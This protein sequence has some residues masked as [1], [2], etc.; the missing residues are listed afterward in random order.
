M[1]LI[2]LSVNVYQKT[3]HHFFFSLLLFPHKYPNSCV[4]QTSLERLWKK[5][6]LITNRWPWLLI[7][8]GTRP[9]SQPPGHVLFT[10][11]FAPSLSFLFCFLSVCPPDI[12]IL[13]RENAGTRPKTAE[14]LHH[15]RGK[16]NTRQQKRHRETEHPASWRRPLFV[17]RSQASKYFL[18]V[19]FLLPFLQLSKQ[20]EMENVAFSLFS[21]PFGW[22]DK[23]NEKK[24]PC[25]I[26]KLR[27]AKKESRWSLRGRK[28]HWQT[29]KTE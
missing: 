16:E 20:K 14:E 26:C 28:R 3:Y 11:T 7:S 10:M 1:E 13:Q 18:W 24:I 17:F 22:L 27:E 5:T 8:N 29:V 23:Q 19:F 9:G 25:G 6:G 4:Q 12:Y 15:K 2:C 21:L